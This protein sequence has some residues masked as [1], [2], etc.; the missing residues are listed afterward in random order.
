MLPREA[1]YARKSYEYLEY[2]DKKLNF[3][4][5]LFRNKNTSRGI[6]NIDKNF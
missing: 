1:K 3:F 2:L 4:N 5:Q 6:Y